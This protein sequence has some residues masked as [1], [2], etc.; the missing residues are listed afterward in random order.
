MWEEHSLL[1]GHLQQ[2]M[3]GCA[4]CGQRYYYGSSNVAQEYV[5][6]DERRVLMAEYLGQHR[7][8]TEG[9]YVCVEIPP[10]VVVGEYGVYYCQGQV[11]TADHDGMLPE[12]TTS[13]T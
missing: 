2:C 5:L 13:T 11:Y 9:W 8:K 1:C 4:D 6:G 3:N 12:E 7:G 10:G